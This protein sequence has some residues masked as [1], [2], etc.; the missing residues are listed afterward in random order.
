MLLWGA[1]LA[2]LVKRLPLVPG[3]GSLL[4]RESASPPPSA[5]PPHCALSNKVYAALTWSSEK[6][7]HFESQLKIFQ[8]TW[9]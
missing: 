3:S 4:S 7:V 2:Q 1:W 5:P 8:S 6:F 9:E